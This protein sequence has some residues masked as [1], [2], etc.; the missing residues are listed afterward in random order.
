MDVDDV[1]M[2]D[3]QTIEE[4][5]ATILQSMVGK[6]LDLAMEGQDP[7]GLVAEATVTTVTDGHPPHIAAMCDGYGWHP[8]KDGVARI[9]IRLA[10][11]VP[12]SEQE[13]E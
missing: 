10:V 13:S 3:G 7:T 6:A 1:Y 9:G 4:A 12:A 2:T 11:D 5:V 8:E